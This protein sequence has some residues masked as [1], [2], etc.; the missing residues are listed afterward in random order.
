MWY[1]QNEFKLVIVHCD[2]SILRAWE[3]HHS[4]TV[5]LEIRGKP[6][7]NNLME[8]CEAIFV[9]KCPGMEE[10]QDLNKLETAIGAVTEVAGRTSLSTKSWSQCE[11]VLMAMRPLLGKLSAKWLD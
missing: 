5:L 2:A 1:E 8:W 4:S 10:Q 6:N 7:W 3:L 9:D 11:S